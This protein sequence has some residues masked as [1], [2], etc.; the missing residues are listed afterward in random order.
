[1]YINIYNIYKQFKWALGL[2][3]MLARYPDS[4]LRIVSSGFSSKEFNQNLGYGTG[5]TQNR[6]QRGRFLE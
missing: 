3:P 6:L 1:M 2:L 5:W 4:Q